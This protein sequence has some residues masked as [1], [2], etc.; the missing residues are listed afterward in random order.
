[1]NKTH[2]I[3]P[4]VLLAV[5]AGGCIQ[6]KTESEIK[7]IHITMDINLKVD[8]ELDK[9]FADENLQKPKGDFVA[10]KALI[11]RG[12]AGITK[13]AM[14][15]PRLGATAEDRIV[16]ADENARRLRRFNDI[17]KT[18]GVTLEEVQK[19]RMAKILEKLPVGA[20]YQEESGA[21]R[22]K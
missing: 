8:K 17:A 14:L 4:V 1:M 11:D 13:R 21:W 22:Q 6:L 16:L 2:Y 5:F 9:A 19:R 3:I 18:S 15:E 7:P 10:I 12:V 20:W